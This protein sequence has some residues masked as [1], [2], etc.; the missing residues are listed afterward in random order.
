MSIFSKI[1]ALVLSSDPA[2]PAAGKVIFYAKSDGLYQRNSA[3]TVTKINSEATAAIEKIYRAT[4]TQASTDAP[5]AAVLENT[6]GGTV[7]WARASE[8]VYTATLASAFTA[9]KTLVLATISAGA[10]GIGAV[11]TRAN[12]VTITTVD[13]AG[14][15]TDDVSFTIQIAVYP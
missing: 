5:V 3:G 9:N 14:A 4:V 10:V 11:H 7:V 13:A 1:H 6:L 15:V 8:G 12:V 2:A